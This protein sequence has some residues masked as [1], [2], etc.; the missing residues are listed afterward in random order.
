[1]R[2]PTKKIKHDDGYC[3]INESDFDPDVHEPYDEVPAAEA[4]RKNE[5]TALEPKP[6]NTANVSTPVT[7]DE[8]RAAILAKT[9]KKPAWNLKP[10]NL[11]AQYNA[12]SEED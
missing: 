3:I 11:L 10:E 1:M 4:K 2:I 8:M 5:G 6:D 12:L 7:E 9:G